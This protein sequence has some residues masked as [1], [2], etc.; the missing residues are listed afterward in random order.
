MTLKPNAFRITLHHSCSNK[1]KIF[2]LA[3][4]WIHGITP[5]NELY[6]TA[7][8]CL[9]LT[10][11]SVTRITFWKFEFFSENVEKIEKK[12]QNCI[13]STNLCN[14][15]Q[16]TEFLLLNIVDQIFKISTI[17][18]TL[19][20]IASWLNIIQAYCVSSSLRGISCPLLS[21]WLPNYI[22]SQEI[23]CKKLVFV[24]FFCPE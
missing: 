22:L 21:T 3:L 18:E 15:I 6:L 9:F 5:F 13:K 17:V 8:K 24:R 2:K 10:A 19:V 23:K 4:I 20:T 16:F 7:P 14:K 1:E 12:G 11:I